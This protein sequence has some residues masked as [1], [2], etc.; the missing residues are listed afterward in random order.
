MRRE[1]FIKACQNG[2]SKVL[3][4]LR[5]AAKQ[6]FVAAKP[7][8]VKAKNVHAQELKHSIKRFRVLTPD[9][10][11]RQKPATE[12]VMKAVRGNPVRKQKIA[13]ALKAFQAKLLAAY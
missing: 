4:H 11:F 9:A 2:D 7:V 3:H 6:L 12:T 5:F 1:A 13:N 8:Y 10:F